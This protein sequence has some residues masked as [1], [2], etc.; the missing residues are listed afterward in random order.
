MIALPAVEE[1][2]E[3]FIIK[4]ESFLYP[5]GF[6]VKF[7]VEGCKDVIVRQQTTDIDIT[8]M[9]QLE[10]RL[11]PNIFMIQPIL[12]PNDLVKI[13]IQYSHNDTEREKSGAYIDMNAH[14]DVTENGGTDKLAL[15]E[16]NIA[17]HRSEVG[18]SI[19]DHLPCENS[20]QISEITFHEAALATSLDKTFDI[21]LYAYCHSFKDVSAKCQI[22]LRGKNTV[23]FLL[24]NKIQKGK[25]FSLT[26]R[27]ATA[28]SGEA[29]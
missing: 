12:A 17:Q 15:H 19:I 21:Y 22:Y 7:Q 20:S 5:L 16:F 10:L 26:A 14:V 11:E 29:D 9:P 27:P 8:I 28:A 24:S 4:Y 3:K 18:I 6:F 2:K 25:D 1:T 23:Q 13:F